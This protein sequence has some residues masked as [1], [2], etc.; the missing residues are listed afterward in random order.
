MPMRPPSRRFCRP[1]VGPAELFDMQ[2]APVFQVDQQCPGMYE[3]GV[4]CGYPLVR[5]VERGPGAGCPDEAQAALE[6]I[7][8]GHRVV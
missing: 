6:A 7:S 4:A 1:R 5:R 2:A 8:T 3:R